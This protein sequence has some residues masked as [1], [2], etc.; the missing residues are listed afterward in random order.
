MQ[1]WLMLPHLAIVLCITQYH[2]CWKYESFIRNNIISQICRVEYWKKL[3]LA[4]WQEPLYCK[5]PSPSEIWWHQDHYLRPHLE[6][7]HLSRENCQWQR[8]RYTSVTLEAAHL[9][10]K[11][12]RITVI[13]KCSLEIHECEQLLMA[14]F[15][16]HHDLWSALEV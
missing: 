7:S 12:F 9:E 1:Q 3:R 8:N 16:E 6:V 5:E 10:H 4:F 11:L 14:Q 2:H 15:Q 13:K